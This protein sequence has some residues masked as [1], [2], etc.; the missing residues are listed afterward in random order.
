M[1]R[2]SDVKF[3]KGG[4]KEMKRKWLCGFLC[5]GVILSSVITAFAASSASVAL[6]PTEKSAE[7]SPV[8]LATTAYAEVWNSNRSG[9][10]VTVRIY[11]AWD[12]WP[13]TCE[14]TNTIAKGGYGSYTESQSKSS[15]FKLRLE[16]G[17][18]VAA[19]GKIY[20]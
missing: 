17:G 16:S 8:G 20:L 12:G 6:Q 9:T 18:L 2:Y 19:V 14:Q 5:G 7:S 1:K 4:G 15:S 10:N 11:A 3:E 13:Y